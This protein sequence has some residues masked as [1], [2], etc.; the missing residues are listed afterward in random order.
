MSAKTY[1]CPTLLRSNAIQYKYYLYHRVV[2]GI[3]CVFV[4]TKKVAHHSCGERPFVVCSDLSFL[5][6]GWSCFVVLLID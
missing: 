3:G 1:K 4:A 5:N 6:V 2:V